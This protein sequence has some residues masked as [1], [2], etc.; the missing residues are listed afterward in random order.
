MSCSPTTSPRWRPQAPSA[1]S[2]WR[3]T[4]CAC[5]PTLVRPRFATRPACKN[6][7]ARRASWCRRARPRPRATRGQA[8]RRAPAA[9]LRTTRERQERSGR[10]LEQLP[11]AAAAKRRNG[12]KPAHSST[13]DADAPGSCRWATRACGRPTTCSSPPTAKARCH[14]R[15][16]AA[17]PGQRYGAACPHARAEVEQRLGRRPEQWL[18]DGGLPAHEQS[19]AVAGKT[20]R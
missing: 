7:W 5:A 15:H 12:G 13:T 17:Q 19:D 6:I 20:E 9:K 10:A 2:A 1:W 3:K 11:E 4:A 14:R 8:S 16:G 18:V